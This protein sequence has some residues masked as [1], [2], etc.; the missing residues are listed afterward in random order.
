LCGALALTRADRWIG[1]R[2]GRREPFW[3]VG[4]HRVTG[5]DED[6]HELDAMPGLAVR[7]RTLEK[8]LDWMGR[9][10]R[11]VSLD[12]LCALLESGAR[13]E[14]PVACVTFDDGY[15]DVYEHAFPLLR[16]KGIP[17]AVF[18][19]S[20]LIGTSIP[21]LHE[22][23]YLLLARALSRRD[24][25]AALQAYAATRALLKALPQD[26]VLRIVQTLETLPGCA[27]PMPE[28]VLPLTWEMLR[29]MHGAGFT[30]GSHTKSHVLLTN[31]G[32]GRV[33]DETD[34]S[35]RVLE[36]RLGIPIAHFAYPDGQFDP[37]VAREVAGAGYRAGFTTC[38]HRDARNPMM[39]IPR[40]MFAEGGALNAFGHFS[41]SL[42]SCHANG[43]ISL[44]SR[45]LKNHAGAALPST[46]AA[47]L[48]GHPAGAH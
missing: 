34:G 40:T 12:D 48:D 45:C 2:S 46:T 1:R 31:E 15:R 25:T 11:F 23:L 7:A 21:P 26:A 17:G 4:F 38:H 16:R 20:D 39:T 9:R 43:V 37:A 14:R 3:V 22:R 44:L 27:G 5:P 13:P 18:V 35:R 47:E 30:I 19:V 8:Q 36:Q 41:P 32:V 24:G 42:M 33:Q 10:Y 28:P 6:E 29:T